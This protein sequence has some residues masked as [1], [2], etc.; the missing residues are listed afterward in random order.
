MKRSHI[1]NIRKAVKKAGDYKPTAE[2]IKAATLKVCPDGENVNENKQEIVD[3]VI[4][5][6]QYSSAIAVTE[7]EASNKLIEP[8]SQPQISDVYG[9]ESSEL[10]ETALT[11]AQKRDL[12]ATEASQ[13]K[14]TLSESEIVEVSENL[15]NQVSSRS[16]FLAEIRGAIRS[17][18]DAKADFQKQEINNFVAETI[19]YASTKFN[20]NDQRLKEGLQ[21]INNFFSSDSARFKDLSKTISTAFKI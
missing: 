14:I 16:E 2:Q 17:F 15:K 13:L 8:I 1:E 5:L 4:N 19:D 3:E 6:I 9:I 21:E 11:V 12:V 7:S 20:H 18:I 10:D